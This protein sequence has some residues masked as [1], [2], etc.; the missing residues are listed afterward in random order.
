MDELERRGFLG[1]VGL[2]GAGALIGA[3]PALAGTIQESGRP[4]FRHAL[5]R[6]QSVVGASHRDFDG[7]RELVDEQPALAKAAWDWGFGD[8]ESALGAAS[9]T[10]AR[11][12]AEYLIARGARPTLFSA[13][14]LGEVDVVRAHVGARPELANAQG[15]HGIPL[16]NHARAG[17]DAS[18]QV[19]EYLIEDCGVEDTPLGVDATPEL[20]ERYG[21]RYV[22]LGNPD[23]GLTVS[24][25]GR[26]LFIGAGEVASSRVLRVEGDT[27]HPTGAPY[28]RLRFEPAGTRAT[29]VV[30][31]DGPDRWTLERS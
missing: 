26:F 3:T 21:G 18:V 6:A 25:T 30:I 28:V 13:A 15:A 24:A 1:L 11:E 12:I 22:D 9:H 31:E 20:Q 5:A 16:L 29:R 17:R 27:F 7:V 8:W 4:G 2:G 19:V 14:M 10:G 23:V